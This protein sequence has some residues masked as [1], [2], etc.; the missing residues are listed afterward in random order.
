[1][2][3]FLA[4]ASTLSPQAL[5]SDILPGFGVGAVAECKF[6]TGGFNHTYRVKTVD[7]STYYLRAYRL[8]WRT[9]AD[10]QYE[11]DLLSHLQRKGFPAARPVRYKDSQP[12][13]AV[14]A[15]EGRRYLALFTE[16]PAAQHRTVS[17]SSPGRLGLSPAVCRNP[18]PADPIDAR[19]CA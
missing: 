1:M 14:P 7:G 11:L 12:F 3:T 17:L 16:A 5:A 18:A 15:P 19:R 8:Q 6:Y 2:T 9:P 13:C 10:I 4:I